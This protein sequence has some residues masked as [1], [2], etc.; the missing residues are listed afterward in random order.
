M[1]YILCLLHICLVI[2]LLSHVQHELPKINFEQ[3]IV[4]FD[5]GNITNQFVM[6]VQLKDEVHIKITH[7]RIIKCGIICMYIIFSTI[8][9]INW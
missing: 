9:Y 8:L 5:Q 6:V 3:L 7:A 4:D 2:N 1:P